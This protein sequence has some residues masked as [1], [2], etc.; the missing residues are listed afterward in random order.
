MRRMLIEE[1]CLDIE[2]AFILIEKRIELKKEENDSRGIF[3]TH[4]FFEDISLDDV[5]ENELLPLLPLIIDHYKELPLKTKWKSYKVFI[6]TLCEIVKNGLVNGGILKT[7]EARIGAFDYNRYYGLLK[8]ALDYENIEVIEKSRKYEETIINEAGIPR[9]YHKKCL[10]LF[11]IYWKWLRGYEYAERMQFLRDYLNGNI[12]DKVYIIDQTDKRQIDAIKEDISSFSEKVLK[13]CM[14]LDAVFAAIERYPDPITEDNLTG[15][16][17][18]INQEVGFDIFTVIRSESLKQFILDYAKKISFNKFNRL[19]NNLPANELVQLPTNNLKQVAEYSLLNYI[20]GRHVIR[21]NIYDV[22]FPAPLSIDDIYGL[23]RDRLHTYGRAVIYTSEEP[24]WAEKDGIERQCRSFYY[25]PYG[26]LYVFYER[27][28]PASY[29]YI[30]G[31]LVDNAEPFSKKSFICKYWNSELQQYQLGLCVDIRYANADFQMRGV[32]L[33][34]NSTVLERGTTNRNGS[35]RI[36]DRIYPLNSVRSESKNS[37]A[38]TV[39]DE[40]IETWD[41][42]KKDLYIWGKQSGLR[43]YDQINLAEWQGNTKIIVFSKESVDNSS[44][45]LNYL[46]TSNDYYVYEGFFD[47]SST[48]IT[49]SEVT[50]PIIKPQYPYIRLLTDFFVG[51]EEYCIEEGR[52]LSI[53][54]ANFDE[55]N[56]ETIIQIEHEQARASFNLKNV[57]EEE[58]L[59]IQ[60]LLYQKDK[61]FL[62][63]VGT[64]DITLYNNSVVVSRI[65]IAILPDLTI[66]PHKQCYAEGELVTVSVKSSTDC[67]E[68][69]GEYIDSIEMEIGKAKLGDSGRYIFAK[70]IEFNCYIDKCAV[71]RKLSFTPNIWALQPRFLNTMEK[72]DGL[73]GYIDKDEFQRIGV[74]VCST[75]KSSVNIQAERIREIKQ[76]KPGYNLIKCKQYLEYAEAKTE[77]IITDD[78][79]SSDS[80]TIVYQAKINVEAPSIT[81]SRVDFLIGYNGP[82]N[83]V[84]CFR[85]FTGPTKIT[86]FKKNVYKN[87]FKT[88]LHIDTELITDD[89]L[90]IEAKVGT[91]DYRAIYREKI[92]IPSFEEENTIDINGNTSLFELIEYDNSTQLSKIPKSVISLLM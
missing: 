18:E 85:V 87:R 91:Q 9:G 72:V 46:Y 58:L 5:L 16:S 69:E 56:D 83:T 25:T 37:F 92:S 32:Q 74:F 17:N 7:I 30:N 24:I 29:L 63:D 54:I 21:G 89:Y 4:I 68:V 84:V 75:T 64:W 71:S 36:A 28:S 77:I 22:S 48:E 14:K 70:P 66:A 59:N 73:G 12:L 3:Y 65:H 81:A 43:V 47:P 33:L 45:E 78:Y 79:G 6:G 1:L 15:I 49:I 34:F 76:I 60:A 27:L 53:A 41:I 20:G 88:V 44:I 38:F 42:E 62:H 39:N 40:F 19:L 90:T 82:V 8:Q 13:T 57:S 26:W 86:E 2:K 11:S 61:H 31:E 51:S 10:E 50:I 55:D 52:L 23:E 35:F 80:I 67:F